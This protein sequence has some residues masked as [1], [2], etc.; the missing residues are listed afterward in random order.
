MTDQQKPAGVNEGLAAVHGQL[1]NLADIVES[2]FAESI[3]ALVES[4]EVAA[5]E[6]RLDDYK[7][8]SV[9]LRVDGLCTGIL[10]T[11]TLSLKEFHFVCGAIKIA[12]DLKLMADEALSID[13]HMALWSPG[14][15]GSRASAETIGPVL[16]SL[17]KA[18]SATASR[19]LWPRT[20]ASPRACTAFTVS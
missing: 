4:D 14:A 11:G 5:Q 10:S 17:P 9:W 7:A 6:A 13:R 18:R 15:Q 1:V 16:R 3:L 20:P 8:H 2:A 12:M 19:P